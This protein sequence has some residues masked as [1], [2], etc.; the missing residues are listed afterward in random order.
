MIYAI[1]KL[2]HILAIVVWIGGMVFAHFFL[3]PAALQLPPPQRVP[4]MHGTLQRFFAAVL[5]SIAT[6]LVSGLW[7]IGRLAKET[8]QAGLAFN[9]PL[10][11][12]IMATLGIVMMAIFGHIRFALFKRLSKAVAASDWP[13][14]GAALASIRTWVGIN[15]AIGV[16]IIVLTLL[17]V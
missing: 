6:V 11:W 3:R 7:M 4:L 16:V 12:T 9:M 13:A 2:L 5:V 15:L 17:M 8:V 1:L 10:D 14:G